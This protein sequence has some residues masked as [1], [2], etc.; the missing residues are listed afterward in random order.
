MPEVKVFDD[1]TTLVSALTDQFIKLAA[2]AAHFNGQ[3]NIALSGGRTPEALYNRLSI[4]SLQSSINWKVIHVY[5][6]DERCVPPDSSMSNYGMV[7]RVLLDRV[8]IPPQNIH[9]IRGETDIRHET[10]RYSQEIITN[11]STNDSETPQFD[12]LFLG[13]GTDGHT[14]SLFPNANSALR[15][16]RFCVSA[17]NP[18][19]GQ[20]RI[21]IT[22]PVINAAKRVSF[23]VTGQEKAAIVD[24]ILSGKD[25]SK[26]CPAAKVAPL[27]KRLDWYLDKAAASML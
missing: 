10:V 23:L 15:P 17:E 22:L 24:K 8:E 13:L 27:S 9:R 18:L 21:S 16:N 2:R 4:P 20:K 5:W 25:G 14:A 6:G 11:L 7:K 26:E 12:W 1:S 19:S 3:F